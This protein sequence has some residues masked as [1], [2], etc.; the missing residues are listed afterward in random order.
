MD[1]KCDC[2][3]FA[4][5][6]AASGFG[7]RR[8]PSNLLSVLTV[9]SLPTALTVLATAGC[10]PRTGGGALTGDLGEIRLHP[11]L[12]VELAAAEPLVFDPVDLEFDED[13]R[14]FVLE[15]PGF[16]FIPPG[17][18]PPGRIVELIDR[19]RDGRFD[20]RRV[21]A[22]HLRYADSILAARG[23]LLVADAPDLLFVKDT[24]G[25]GRADLRQV[26]LTGFGEG[27]SESN[28]NGLRWGPDNWIHGANGSSGGSVHRPGRPEEATSIRGRDF[29]LRLAPADD[30]SHRVEA[31][32]FETTARMGGGFGLDFD[33]WGRRFVTHEQRH[34]QVEVFPERYLTGPHPWPSTVTE[35]SDH[36]TGETARVF[37]VSKPEPRP[38][39]PEQA[40]YFTAGC[41]LTHYGGSVLPERFRGAFFVA[42]AVHNLVHLDLVEPRGASFVARRERA[43]E[44]VLAAVDNAFRPVNFAVGPEGALYVLDMHRG[45]I[46][47]PE[48][49][50][51]EIEATLDLRAG[52]DQGR[53]LRVVPRGGLAPVAVRFDRADLASAMRALG[54]PD[55]WWRDTAQRL[56]VEWRDD[57]AIRPLHAMAANA[58]DPRARLHARWTLDGLGALDADGVLAALD[59]PHPR[60]REAA[61]RLAEPFLAVPAVRDRA[62]AL[63]ADQDAR[64]A[65][66]AALA[67]GLVLADPGVPSAAIADQLLELAGRWPEDPW[68]GLAIRAAVA[69]RPAELAPPLILGL[70]RDGADPRGP[71]AA[72]V[73]G[74][75]ALVGDRAVAAEHARLLAAVADLPLDPGSPRRAVLRGLA[76]GLERSAAET[77]PTR[78]AGGLRDLLAAFGR[79]DDAMLADAWRVARG[80]GLALDAGA[81][82]R[83]E[84]AARIAADP[85]ASTAE[86]LG[87]LALVELA[88]PAG[89]LDL[90][91]GLL[92]PIQPPELQ[93]AA[94]DQLGRV[95]QAR[96]APRLIAAWPSLGPAVRR[97]AG[98]LLLLRR[99]NHGLLLDALE[100]GRIGVGELTLDLE[101]RRTL[102]RGST[103]EIAERAARL[104]GDAGV[105]TRREVYESLLPALR[106][107]G[108]AARGAVT[109][110][111]LCSRCHRIADLGFAVGPDLTDA[112]R[113][114]GESL[115]HDVVDPNA[116]LGAEHVSYVVTLDDGEVLTGLVED[117]EDGVRIRSGD[118]DP[119]GRWVPRVRIAE[120]RS[121]GI[122]L[123]PEGLEAGLAP[124]DVADLIAF[125]QRPR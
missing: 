38:N 100:R 107:D 64:V 104:F 94:M 15:M 124:Q 9:L 84:R 45:V 46:E 75:A 57:A 13:G 98:D 103:P 37:P 73:E 18:E 31:V 66:Q 69:R 90:L 42:E 48:W 23:G 41:G 120:L 65:L 11:E 111:A 44:E 74:L 76:S 91:V 77:A 55:Q 117:G 81:R 109:F 60:L 89:R 70:A 52:A 88:E 85:R 16:P 12:A 49:I 92:A 96:A 22:D 43:R 47:H 40:G 106:L 50:P 26:L 4:I 10:T 34:I 87:A 95:D 119:E 7:A 97:R 62:L 63:L 54:H 105:D 28:F 58:E 80:L 108:D 33:Q 53:I 25:D 1:S 82:T 24:D 113:K 14:A 116:A 101:R 5:A 67:A 21:F 99:E 123:M 125:L 112:F 61:L 29:R 56:L 39:H 115:L 93:R 102:L 8:S 30:D 3:S 68:I 19:D 71:A 86:R 83:A 78:G 35:I 114:S 122:S 20:A 121:T 110:A 17:E 72:R 32:G 51:D 2:G 118:A 79:G 6:A 27:P 36:G 59:D